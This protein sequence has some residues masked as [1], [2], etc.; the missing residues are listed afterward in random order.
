VE[1][2]RQTLGGAVAIAEQLPGEQSERL[3]NAA[4]DVFTNSFAFTA[5][6]CV[7]LSLLT[8]LLAFLLLRKATGDG[9]DSDPAIADE[10]EASVKAG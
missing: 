10:A 6:I 1:A 4:R 9:A 7:A 8:A 3:L 5:S 2:A